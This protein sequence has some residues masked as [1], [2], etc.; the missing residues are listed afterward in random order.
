M[1]NTNKEQMPTAAREAWRAYEA[2]G[3]DEDLAAAREATVAARKAG[4]DLAEISRDEGA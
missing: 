3:T 4:V 2:S 1:A